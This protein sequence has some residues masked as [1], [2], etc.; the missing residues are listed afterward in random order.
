MG[1][2]ESDYLLDRYG[3]CGDSDCGIC[4]DLT[5]RISV[6]PSNKPTLENLDELF[7]Y[8]PPTPATIPKFNAINEASKA[9]AKVILETCPDCA[10][11]SAAIRL[12]VNARMTANASI[13][14]APLESA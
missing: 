8:H 12:V 11:R 2:A 6:H 5:L 7:T 4:Y 1:I 14:C 3:D 9:L 10:D 13:A